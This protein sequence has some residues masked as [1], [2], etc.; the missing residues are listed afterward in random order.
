VNLAI[1]FEEADVPLHERPVRKELGAGRAGTLRNGEA[2]VADAVATRI[3]V[4]PD[5]EIK[6]EGAEGRTDTA[7]DVHFGSGAVGEGD[8]LGGGTDVQLQVLGHVIARL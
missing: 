3:Q 4:T 8:A 6:G 2:A 5:A 7:V 1:A